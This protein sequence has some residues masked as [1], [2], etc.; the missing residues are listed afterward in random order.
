MLEG[1]WTNFISLIGGDEQ[2]STITVFQ[3]V[4]RTVVIYLVA[5]VIIRIGKRRFMGDYSAFDIL[6][7]LIVGSTMAR[8][9]TGT[10]SL[11]NMVIVVGVLM[12]L[13]WI[14]ATLSVHWQGFG[15]FIENSPRKLI[16][17]GAIQ[18]DALLKSK[19]TRDDLM[20]A[21]RQESHIDDVE[22]VKAA[23]LERDG[24]I[25]VLPKDSV[26]TVQNVEVEKG[27]QTIKI[28]N[29]SSPE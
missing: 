20:L 18:D 1:L 26:N 23:Y 19:I 13:H 12:A 14:I 8:A 2:Y 25:T 28:A 5:L 4:T 24:S 16:I 10:I 27:V 22:L 9:V 15:R 6:I 11:L 21:L 7:G 3:V 17:D 29:G